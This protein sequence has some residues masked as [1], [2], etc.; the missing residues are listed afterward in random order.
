MSIA[1]LVSL[2][3]IV[4]CATAHADNPEQRVVLKGGVT[5]FM[6]SQSNVPSHRL[7]PVVRA[8]WIRRYKQP[9]AFGLE[10]MAV[11]DKNKNYRLMGGYLNI[12]ALMYSGSVF[13]CWWMGGWGLG[14]APKILYTDLETNHPVTVYGHT[15]FEF[16]WWVNDSIALGVDLLSENLT[17]ATLDATIGFRF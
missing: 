16:R 5:A 12:H 6:N 1:R 17:Q 13:E 11:A 7:K 8:E 3:A 14:N 10:L 9:V 2:M 15:G 4:F